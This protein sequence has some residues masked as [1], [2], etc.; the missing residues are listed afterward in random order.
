MSDPRQG[1][2][3]FAAPV[4]G[5]GQLLAEVNAMLSSGWR[6]VAVAGQACEVRRYASGHV[7]FSLK[8]E[9]AKLAAVLWRSDAA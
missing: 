8:D 5:V 3:G 9:T 6:R 1:E 7:Y 2:L 4:Y